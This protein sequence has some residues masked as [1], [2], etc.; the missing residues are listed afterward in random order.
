MTPN[1]CPSNSSDCNPLDNYVWGAVD[2]KTNKTQRDTKDK[3]KAK[4]TAPLINLNKEIVRKACRR[5]QCHREAV[6]EANDDFFE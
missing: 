2:R 6:I 4:I 3:L 5:F 1:I